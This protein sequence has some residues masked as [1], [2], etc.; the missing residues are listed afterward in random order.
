MTSHKTRKHAR[1]KYPKQ[2]ANMSFDKIL[3]LTAL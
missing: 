3:D 2:L 1:S